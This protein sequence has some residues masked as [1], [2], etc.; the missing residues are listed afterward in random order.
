M[1]MDS[2]SASVSW[3]CLRGATAARVNSFSGA[4][5]HFVGP[6]GEFYLK[7]KLG[8]PQIAVEI[9]VL[10]ILAGQGAPVARP[11]GAQDGLAYVIDHGDV[12]CLYAA[13][14]GAPCDSAVLRDDVATVTAIGSALGRLHVALRRCY[15]VAGLETFTD[16]VQRIVTAL[17]HEQGGP[18]DV[19][20]LVA[21]AATLD[22]TDALPRG[23]IHRDFHAGN[24]LFDRGRVA[25]ILDFDSVMRGPRL[26]DPCYLATSILMSGFSGDAN[27]ARWFGVLRAALCGYRSVVPLTA[28]E[29][30]NV[31]TMLAVIQMI[32]IVFCLRTHRPEMA[33]QNERALFWLARHRAELERHL[34]S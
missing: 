17:R 29:D 23:L 32:F 15:A 21:I 20:R 25:G 28:I 8:L 22:S 2:R 3:A 10:G 6:Q 4:V 7:R 24:V 19:D 30:A 31:F 16:P 33:L 14:P 27:E 13:L 5:T 26:F 34:L 1:A 12:Y 9:E 11:V 18:C